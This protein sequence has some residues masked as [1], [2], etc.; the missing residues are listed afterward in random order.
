MLWRLLRGCRM[1][2]VFT[3]DGVDVA[4]SD[5]RLFLVG[6]LGS[7]VDQGLCVP[8][9]GSAVIVQL[10]DVLLK[11]GAYVFEGVAQV[12]DYRVVAQN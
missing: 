10:D 9:E 2:Q 12:P 7:F 6:A 3:A 11:V 8:V 5:E 1:H 4:F